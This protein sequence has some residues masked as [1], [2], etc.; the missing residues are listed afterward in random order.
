[1]KY[2]AVVDPHGFYNALRRALEDAGFFKNDEDGKLI[3]C[4]DLLDR[5]PDAQKLVEFLTGLMEEDRLIYIR[6]NHEELLSLLLDDVI[7]GNVWSLVDGSSY[8]VKNGTWHTA[9]QLSGMEPSEVCRHPGD[10]VFRVKQS[11]Y[12]KK[13]LRSAVDYFETEHYVFVH[14]WIPTVEEAVPASYHR[15]KTYR[16]D[17]DWRNASEDRWKAAR[18]LN[19]MDMAC[20]R[21]ITEPGKTVVCGHFHTSYGHSRISDACPEYGEGA[22]FTPFAADG[23]LALDACTAYTGKVNCIV[24]E[25]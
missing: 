12:Y 3:V 15:L 11:P 21:G 19:G 25:D 24:I 20:R 13:L 16:Y 5:G 7:D 17:P 22:I 8:H 4:G 6:G 23:I 14:G 2:F 10:F 9:L 1:M 18:W